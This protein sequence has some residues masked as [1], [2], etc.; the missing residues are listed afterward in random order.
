M[1]DARR[2]PGAF[3]FRKLMARN[4]WLAMAMFVTGGFAVGVV[5]VPRLGQPW[6]TVLAALVA[7]GL[8]AV[9]RAT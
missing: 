5:I 7:A 6:S 4:V 9:S 8:R 3:L 1:H 2:R